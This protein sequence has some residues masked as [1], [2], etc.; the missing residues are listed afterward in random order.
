[1]SSEPLASLP[2]WARRML[3]EARVGH[4]GLLDDRDHPRVLPV[5]YAFHEGILWSAIDA[6][7]KRREP[8]R[9]RYLARRP[10]ATLTVDRYAEDW[11]S[12]A[13]VQVLCS[14]EILD[15]ARALAALAALAS[16]Y[17]QYRDLP[18]PGPVLRLVPD[19]AL[20]W[21]AAGEAI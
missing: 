16:K 5:T 8:A 20:C 4:L 17:D 11:S 13:W 21:R 14:A 18:P 15:R 12:L 10:R 6:K 19:R 2:D 9:L 7:P 1:M 3:A